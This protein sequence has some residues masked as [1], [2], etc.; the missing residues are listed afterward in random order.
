MSFK[1]DYGF[2]LK[3]L[4]QNKFE[5]LCDDKNHALSIKQILGNVSFVTNVVPTF[6]MDEAYPDKLNGETSS[7]E[8]LVA[9]LKAWESDLASLE[10]SKYEDH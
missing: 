7:Q 5:I 8:E 10:V 2:E 4:D 3:F 1:S 6:D 9:L